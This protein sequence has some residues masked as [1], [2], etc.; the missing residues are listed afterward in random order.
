MMPSSIGPTRVNMKVVE[1]LS[2]SIFW[3]LA[4]Y[5]VVSRILIFAIWVGY[6]AMSPIDLNDSMPHEVTIDLT[7]ADAGARFSTIIVRNDSS[8]YLDIAQ[9]GYE[10]RSFDAQRV[11]NWAFFPL[12]PL[13]WHVVGADREH[14]FFAVFF[15][16]ILFAAGLAILFFVMREEGYSSRAAECAIALACFFPSSYFFSLPLSESLFFALCV[17]TFWAAQ[18]KRWPLC[19]ALGVLTTAAR[20]SGIFL[21]VAIA[22][23]V[24]Q[25]RRTLPRG[26]WVAVA[27]MPLGTLAFCGWLYHVCGD[28]LAFVDIQSAWGRSLRL[29]VKSLGVLFV[30]PWVWAS[31][32]NLRLLNVLT[33]F[34]GTAASVWLWRREKRGLALFLFLS[35]LAPLMTGSITSMSRY[36]MG[37][38]P[39]LVAAAGY[40]E[41]SRAYDVLLASSAF[42]LAVLSIAYAANIAFGGA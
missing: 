19:A 22:Y 27:L 25:D 42:L 41:N 10:E 20:L 8:W 34:L 31:D 35:L 17:V 26:T 7:R 37:S 11:A 39:F 15:S 24:W 29:P 30:K 40:L 13:L 33:A 21:V 14:P 32:W 5:F 1:P 16:N 6:A 18:T 38:F 4:G 28:P 9:A 12:T 36:V 2:A 23:M 3:R